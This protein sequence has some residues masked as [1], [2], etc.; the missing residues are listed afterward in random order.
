MNKAHGVQRTAYS[1]EK[2][3]SLFKDA[4]YR[5]TRNKLALFG[6][7]VIFFFIIITI[8]TP[9]IAPY[10]YEEQNLEYGA[11]APSFK[12]LLG[13]DDLGRDLFTRLLYGGRVSLAVGILATLV[14]L[15]IGVS[16]GAISGFF[17]KKTDLIMMRIV[18]ILYSMPFMFFVIILMVIAGRNIYNLFIALGAI[19]WLT[20]SRI[21][22][23]QI[24]SLKEKDFV[25]AAKAIGVTKMKIIFRHL[26]PNALGPIIIYSTLTIPSVM[27]EEA[28]LSF[29]GLGVQ[30]PMSSWGLL[31]ASGVQS[32]ETYPWLL[33][34]PALTMAIILFSL[35]FVG[36]G[37]RDALDPSDKND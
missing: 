5:L 2:T 18:D 4:V 33:I 9:L 37:L 14:S 7:I 35:N 26:I 24:L 34:F 30:P 28:F 17:G 36:D 27:L 31:V 21:V 19:Q 15:I 16:Y 22:R 8:I 12:H 11:Q 13:T 10:G 32:M 23:G 3:S 29:L 1:E 25:M 20:M 6:L